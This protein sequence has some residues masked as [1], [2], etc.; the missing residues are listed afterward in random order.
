MNFN[1]YFTKML[2]HHAD[3]RKI[4]K[5]REEKKKWHLKTPKKILMYINF[6]LKSMMPTRP[7]CMHFPQMYMY[8]LNSTSGLMRIFC[9]L[10]NFL[11]KSLIYWLITLRKYLFLKSKQANQTQRCIPCMEFLHTMQKSSLLQYIKFATVSGKQKSY[12]F[13]C[14]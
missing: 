3:K 8:E 1:M 5:K 7:C 10:V 9:T 14:I 6:V 13:C 4:N 12:R 2:P 11:L